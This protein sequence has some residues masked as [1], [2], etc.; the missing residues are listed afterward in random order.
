MSKY[1]RGGN[2]G[3]YDQLDRAIYFLNTLSI[4]IFLNF[5]KQTVK[6]FKSANK[7]T[8]HLMFILE[9]LFLQKICA[10]RT[11]LCYMKYILRV[12][13]GYVTIYTSECFWMA[14]ITIGYL[15]IL[16]VHYT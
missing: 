6:S 5:L 3:L 13:C 16:H 2:S 8:F 11:F 12:Y 4:Y 14:K 15:T 7:C 9:T 10:L 1:V